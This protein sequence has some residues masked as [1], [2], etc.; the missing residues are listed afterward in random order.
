MK[1]TTE[2]FSAYFLTLRKFIDKRSN[3]DAVSVKRDD[4]AL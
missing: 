4:L 3:E 2:V 1:H